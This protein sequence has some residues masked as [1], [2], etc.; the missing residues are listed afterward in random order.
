M[1]LKEK[2]RISIEKGIYVNKN[3]DCIGVSKK[4]IG[5][6]FSTGYKIYK[7]RYQGKLYKCMVHQLQAYQKYGDLLF[8]DGIVVRHLK[9][10]PTDNS[11]DNICIGTQSE[12]MLDKPKYVR[13]RV[14]LKA[15]RV[16]QDNIRPLKERY[17]IYKLLYKGY[18]Y[19]S[20]MKLY[21]IAKGTLS[22][23]KNY[24]KE[25]KEFIEKQIST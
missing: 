14:A 20:I 18:S 21:N 15:T 10:D 7:F 17:E 2:I 24:S 8:N 23:M 9:G 25:Y 13:E 16:N 5:Y 12:N 11:W 19:S 3:G 6:I 22:Y 4:I 1:T